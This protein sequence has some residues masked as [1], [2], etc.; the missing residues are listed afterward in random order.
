MEAHTITGVVKALLAFYKSARAHGW[1]QISIATFVRGRGNHPSSNPFIESMQALGFT[2]HTIRERGAFDPRAQKALGELIA[3]ERPDIIETH[4]IKAHVLLRLLRRRPGRWVA[5][6]HG[7]TTQDLKMR[8]Y[9]RLNPWALR[10][11]DQVITVCESFRQALVREGVPRHR[12]AVLGNAIEPFS[13]PARQ[14]HDVATVVAIGRLSAEKGHRYLLDAASLVRKARPELRVRVILV[15]DG[16]ERAR[17]QQKAAGLGISDSVEFAGHQ[18]DPMPYYAAADVF[19]LPSLTEGSPLALLEAMMA[20][21][22][23]IATAAGG[24]PETVTNERSALL[25]PSADPQALAIAIERLLTDSALAAR[26]RDHA[27]R[28]VTT[29]HTP[30][31]YAKALLNIYRGLLISR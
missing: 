25:V 26:L 1:A 9:N 3:R 10:G 30:D 16:P 21:V 4:A 17:L 27:Y 22:P 14:P 12:I 31:A 13:V 29:L 18:A 11:A 23:V 5:F 6:H 15:G 24:I 28:D 8:L 19:V 7:Y 2:V 20:R